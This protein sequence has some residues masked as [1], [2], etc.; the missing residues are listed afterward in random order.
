MNETKRKILI[1]DDEK[2]TRDVM[3]RA[4]GATY[5]CLT[6]PDA[7]L[8][9][10]ALKANPDVALMISDVRMPGESG[11]ELLKKAKKANPSLVCIL[12]TAYGTVDLAVEAMKD[13]ADDFMTK[14]IT[15]LDQLE[16][17]VASA[18]RSAGLERKA[19][20]GGSD[21]GALKGF[22]GGSPAMEKIYQLIRKVAPTTATVLIEGPSGSGKELAARAIHALSKRSGGPFVALECSAFEGELLKSE[23]F[24]YV[25]GTFTGALKEGKAGCFEAADGGTLF[26]DE[27]GEI[28]MPTQTALLRTLETRSVRRLGSAEEKPVDFRLVTA[29]NRD[30]S[31]M[32]S[33]GAF[34]ED[35]YYRLNVI[36]I[37]MPALKDH[38]EDIA[39]LV[40]RFIGDFSQRNGG[41]V[42]GIAPDALKALEEYQWPG[43]VRQLRNAIE[44]MCVLA[45]GDT[46]TVEDV[47]REIANPPPAQGTP[48]EG[49]TLADTEKDTILRIL[50][51]CGGNKSRA[52]EKLGIS[53]RNLH[54]KLREWRSE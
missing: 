10:K 11:V 33:E 16:L 24:G 4:L 45:S 40:D 15:D 8:A 49:E 12:L 50:D 28:D 35:L 32:V 25:P 44:K 48:R 1:V 34:R 30:L 14:P 20:P 41:S 36:D 53:R 22:T 38:R 37:R 47:P 19:T 27:I 39:P 3:A 17:R 23:L 52:A 9:M 6:A 5:D 21:T 26:L 7:A 51:E 42:T 18:I 31:K 54:R 29:T 46:L 43:N 2:P 13:G